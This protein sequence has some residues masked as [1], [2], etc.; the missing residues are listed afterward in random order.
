M[1]LDTN[2]KFIRKVI[3]TSL[4]NAELQQSFLKRLDIIE[5]RWNDRNLY[6][7]I[8]GEFSSGKSTLINALIGRD[9]FVTNSIQGTTTIITSIRYGSSINL[10]IRYKNGEFVKYSSHKLSLIEKYLPE[11]YCQ[12][13]I[14]DKIKIKTGDIFSL[15]GKDDYMLK[16][17]DVI[18]TSNRISVDLD[19]VIVY[20]P[21]DF[22][23]KGIVLVDT[24]GTDSL[25]DSHTEITRNAIADKCDLS[26]VIIPALTP[27]SKTLSDFIIENLEHCIDHCHFLV[28]KIELIKEHER[29]GHLAGVAKRLI[30]MIEIDMPHVIA[31]L[32]LLSLEERKIIEPTG[33]LKELS[34]DEKKSLLSKYEEDINGLFSQIYENKT[35]SKE[36]TSGKHIK[37]LLDN[38]LSEM[39]RLRDEKSNI[40]NNK[41]LNRT[42]PLETL[43]DSLNREEL[44][45]LHELVLDRIRST[46]SSERD[47]FE[48][49]MNADIFKADS[50]DEIQR[51]IHSDIAL[52]RGQQCYTECYN[53]A[54]NQVDWMILSYRDSVSKLNKKFREAYALMPIEYECD[55]DAGSVPIKNYKNSFS[56]LSLTTFPLKRMFVKKETIRSEMR[57]AVS[58]YLNS[59]ISRLIEYY[60]S[61]INEIEKK[62]NRPIDKLLKQYIKKYSRTI[63]ARIEQEYEEEKMISGEIEFINGQIRELEQVL[64]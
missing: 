21:A 49:D 29:Q 42:I 45:I 20:Y 52:K 37:V 12:L 13:S 61:K 39:N 57:E 33:L 24:P 3:K 64:V 4:L 47:A 31:A 1:D 50:K 40:L 55:I 25:I 14:T 8:V 44:S 46:F 62:L 30:N 32:T 43:L 51:T 7:G 16:I 36:L 60:S 19:E 9:Y 27:V 41:R 38:V 23:K 22:L 10:E 35:K 11:E 17:F 18:T 28:T 34:I 54:I 2:I 15:N 63:E 58:N 26:F 5:R 6:V 59:I 48:R 56:S 53:Y